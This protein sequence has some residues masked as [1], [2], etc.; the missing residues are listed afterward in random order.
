M[1]LPSCACLASWIGYQPDSQTQDLA[2]RPENGNKTMIINILIFYNILQ[3]LQVKCVHDIQE[4]KCL[5]S[6]KIMV[7]LPQA[8]LRVLIFK[9]KICF[10]NNYR[11]M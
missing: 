11:N 2:I 3:Q 8:P 10:T 5:H 7:M 9:Y 1:Y 6:K 4:T